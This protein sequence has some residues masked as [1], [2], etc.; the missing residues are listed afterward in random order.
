WVAEHVSAAASDPACGSDR[1]YA[2]IC[3]PESIGGSQR[4]RCSSDP[5]PSNGGHDR[6]CTLTATAIA[7]HRAAISSST[8]RYTSNGCPPPPHSSGWGRLSNPA[9]P[10]WANTPSG[11]D[12][13]F[14][15]PSTIG[16]STLSAT[17][18][19][20]T[21]RSA[22]SSVGSR[23]STGMRI[24]PFKVSAHAYRRMRGKLMTDKQTGADVAGRAAP[25]IGVVRE[26]AD[27]ERR[28]ALVPKA[29]G[30]LGTRGLAVVVESGAGE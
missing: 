25:V 30:A 22:A 23:R 28:V 10:S 11:Y 5:N 19:A 13:A 1:L 8:C 9:A 7:A 4:W 6:L 3:S 29:V 16:V 26:S 2:P 24:P 17:L 15:W 12:S 14:S 18:R 27:G 21:M 20:R